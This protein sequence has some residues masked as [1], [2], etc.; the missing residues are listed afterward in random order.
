[1]TIQHIISE[2]ER[3]APPAL[4][5]SYDN[6]GLIVGNA[7]EPCTGVLIN[8]DVTEAVLDEAIFHG[9]NL[10]IT[11]HPIWFSS[12]KKLTPQDYVGRILIKAIKNNL[13]LY[14]IHTNLDNLRTGV[15][16]RI[17]ERLALENCRILSPNPQYDGNIGA[18]MLGTLPEPMPK[19]DFLSFVKQCFDCESIRYADSP[20]TH[21]H[22]VAICGGSGSFLLP[23]ALK[24][25]AHAFITADITYHKFFE[26]EQ[27]ILYLDIGHYESEQFTSSLVCD[28]LSEKF[29]NF[30][31][32][33]SKT[34]TNPVHYL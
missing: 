25:G 6:V 30:A 27:K 7:E 28:Y 33:L 23:Q 3:W 20:H 19:A 22:S 14:A 26:N 11:H 10:V 12:R 16:H 34:Y 9:C 5:E 29:P 17:A 4:A 24:A 1:M 2:L 18:G 32:Y 15:N 31:L 13:S 8:L 21:I